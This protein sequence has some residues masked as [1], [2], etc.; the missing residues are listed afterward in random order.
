MKEGVATLYNAFAFSGTDAPYSDLVVAPGHDLQAVAAHLD[1]FH[2][3]R[4]PTNELANSDAAGHVPHEH[5]A[6][7]KAG[8]YIDSRD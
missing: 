5:Y 7:V 6:I 4:M 3:P 1:A 8:E 2:D